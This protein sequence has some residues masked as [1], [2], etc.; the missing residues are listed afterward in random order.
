MAFFI[1]R[2]DPNDERP[3]YSQIKDEV[4]R[5]IAVGALRPDGPLPSTRQLAG[6][7]R[8]NHLTVQQAYAELEREGVVY[9]RRGLGTFVAADVKVEA[10]R[11]ALARAVGRRA[12]HDAYRH[13]LTSRELL[14]VIRAEAGDDAAAKPRRTTVSRR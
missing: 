2:I 5:G 7:L 8:I 14:S 6:H 13:G 1:N 3:I 9:F 12:L 11:Q 4:R 10:Q